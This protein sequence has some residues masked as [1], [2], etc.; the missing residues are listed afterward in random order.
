MYNG[1]IG[2]LEDEDVTLLENNHKFI[3]KK[4]EYRFSI[5]PVILVDF[6]ENIKK[7]ENKNKK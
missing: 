5:D 2:I 4:N 1:S 6:F 3:Q 7:E